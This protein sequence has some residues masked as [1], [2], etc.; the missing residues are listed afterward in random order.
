MNAKACFENFYQNTVVI[1]LFTFWSSS[2][3]HP[4]DA[5]STSAKAPLRCVLA[6][7]APRDSSSSSCACRCHLPV[8]FIDCMWETCHPWTV[9]LSWFLLNLAERASCGLKMK[10]EFLNESGGPL[11]CLKLT[12]KHSSCNKTGFQACR[13][14]LLVFVDCLHVVHVLGVEVHS[15]EPRTQKKNIGFVFLPKEI[16]KGANLYA[17]DRS[18]KL[19]KFLTRLPQDLNKT[20]QYTRLCSGFFR[21]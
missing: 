17:K 16:Q 13:D 2:S 11:Q 21:K 19:F 9:L 1:A 18:R 3:S 12:L 7:C 14:L 10:V 15:A 6:G 5:F 4:C 20:L 8:R